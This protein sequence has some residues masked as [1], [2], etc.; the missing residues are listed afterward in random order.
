MSQLLRRTDNLSKLSVNKH[1]Y[2]FSFFNWPQNIEDDSWWQSP[3]VLSISLTEKFEI[4]SEEQLKKLSKWE[5]VNTFSL[6]YTGELELIHEV[7]RVLN[8]VTLKD[9]REYLF[10]L[11]D[12]ENQHMW[13]FHKFCKD[14]T[15]TVYPNRKFQLENPVLTPSEEQF[16]IFA[17]ILI[18]EEIGHHYNIVNAKDER[19]HPFIREINEE[20]YKDESRHI[21][22]GRQLLE[23]L[24]PAA[25]EGEGSPQML[26][27][28][29]QTSIDINIGALYNTSAYRDAGILDPLALRTELMTNPVRM[30][31]HR[32]KLLKHVTRLLIRCGIPLEEA[33]Q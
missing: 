25:L 7:S 5:C 14:Y 24:A 30:E 19:V 4:F 1:N 28:Q 12:E 3:D 22:Y 10:H 27:K 17:R 2:A 8:K 32:E 20:H 33:Y 31:F 29:L 9:A 6:N 13:Y 21:A 18:F 11:I 16:L 15:N 23:Y 26:A